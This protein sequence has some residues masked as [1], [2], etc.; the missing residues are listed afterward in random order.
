MLVWGVGGGLIAGYL[1]VRG[2][3]A[4]LFGVGP[5]DPLAVGG[6]VVAMSLAVLLATYLPARRISRIDPTRAIRAE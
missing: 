4:V 6:T 2:A 1:A 5:T 3:D